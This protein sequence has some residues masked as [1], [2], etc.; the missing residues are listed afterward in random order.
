MMDINHYTPSRSMLKTIGQHYCNDGNP[1][2]YLCQQL[3][4]CIGGHD[5][6]FNVSL[7]PTLLEHIPDTFVWKDLD[8]ISQLII[9]GIFKLYIYNNFKCLNMNYKIYVYYYY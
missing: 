6:Y 5:E 4:F 9:T 1:I 2:R 3:I 8:H 7:F